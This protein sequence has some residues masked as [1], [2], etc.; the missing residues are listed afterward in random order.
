MSLRIAPGI[1]IRVG[2]RA[3]LVGSL[4]TVTSGL[5][6]FARTPLDAVYIRDVLPA[7]VLMGVG[8]SVAFPALMGLAMSGATGP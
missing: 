1:A 5:V 6:F 7:M 3:A 4:L 2:A 8:L